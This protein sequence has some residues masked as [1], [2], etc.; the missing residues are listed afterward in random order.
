MRF[1]SPSEIFSKYEGTRLTLIIERAGMQMRDE[2]EVSG[3]D[4]ETKLE[5]NWVG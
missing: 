3:G 5:M 2:W 1:V 4:L